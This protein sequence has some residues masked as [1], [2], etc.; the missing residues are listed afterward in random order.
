MQSGLSKT[1][2]SSSLEVVPATPAAV[3]TNVASTCLA[4]AGLMTDGLAR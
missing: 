3:S 4:T 1:N 2:N